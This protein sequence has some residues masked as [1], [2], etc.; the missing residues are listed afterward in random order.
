MPSASDPWFGHE[1][2]L[3]GSSLYMTEVL[4]CHKH[5][6]VAHVVV[7]SFTHTYGSIPG[8]SISWFH[9]CSTA[10]RISFFFDIFS[11]LELFLRHFNSL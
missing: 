1:C 4:R 6:V 5:D 8:C 9:Q 11:S 10:F 3:T 2:E 7:V